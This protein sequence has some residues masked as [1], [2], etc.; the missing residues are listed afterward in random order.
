MDFDLDPLVDSSNSNPFWSLLGDENTTSAFMTASQNKS[1]FWRNNHIAIRRLSGARITDLESA[2]RELDAVFRFPYFGF[3][4]G[5]LFDMLRWLGWILPGGGYVLLISDASRLLEA[6][7]SE[8]AMFFEILRD[9]A[10]CWSIPLTEG[11]ARGR[12]SVA[13]PRSPSRSSA[14]PRT[15][16]RRWPKADRPSAEGSSW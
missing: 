7:P 10:H 15:A 6:E 9:S 4:R 12:P 5:A 2:F 3:N 1:F 8:R 14:G 16:G 11:G 13:R